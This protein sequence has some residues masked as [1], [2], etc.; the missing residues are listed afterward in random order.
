MM[1]LNHYCSVLS[2]SKKSFKITWCWWGRTYLCW[3]LYFSFSL[4]TALITFIFSQEYLSNYVYFSIV[5]AFYRT[6]CCSFWKISL[7]IIQ[8]EIWDVSSMGFMHY[9]Y[10]IWK[11]IDEKWSYKKIFSR[12]HQ[13]INTQR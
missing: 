10:H 3:T 1:K 13:M 2:V 5:V 11:F 9:K 8:Q 6:L 4:A 7:A 12:S